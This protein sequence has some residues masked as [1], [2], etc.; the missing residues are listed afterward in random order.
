MTV[1]DLLPFVDNL[2]FPNILTALKIFW[3]HSSDNLHM[4][5]FYFY[6][7][8]IE[9]LPKEHYDRELVTGTCI[10][11]CTSGYKLKH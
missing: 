9:D 2:S 5:A 10:A 7:S 6:P 11:E 8:A 1:Q 3:N 4:R